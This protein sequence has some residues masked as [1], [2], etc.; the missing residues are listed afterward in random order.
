[1]LQFSADSAQ[2]KLGRPAGAFRIDSN[3]AVQGMTVRIGAARVL[4]A[5]VAWATWGCSAAGDA[6]S[7]V[8]AG[9]GAV[10]AGGGAAGA[11]VGGAA[12][13]GGATGGGGQAGTGQAGGQAGAPAS[14]GASPGLATLGSLVILG[15]SISDGGGVSPFYYDLL[16]ADL[17]NRYGAIQYQ[18]N[19]QGGSKTGALEGQIDALPGALPG[20]VAVC[21]TSGG[22]DMKAELAAIVTNTDGP[23]R[24]Q[25]G[26]NVATALE[27]LLAP[28]RFGAGVDVHVFEAN[29]YDA[30]DGQGNFGTNGCAFGKGL[31]AIPSDGFYANWNGEISQ[32]VSAKAQTLNDIHQLF[33]MHGFNHPPSWYASDCT[34][35]SAAGHDQLRR[36]FYFEI[37][38]QALP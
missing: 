24:A 21:I 5:F 34:H 29:I 15:D 37:T 17:A 13:T 25:M 8:S 2:N 1:M 7:P 14:G 11:A 33:W 26:A 27:A 10:G 30:S 18:N 31:P 20:P 3:T 38:G 22:N 36:Q 6:G 35:P 28:G 16:H 23:A 12:G 9:S 19:A 4:A 32:Q